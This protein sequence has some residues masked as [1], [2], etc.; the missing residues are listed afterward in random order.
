MPKESV[1][2][3]KQREALELADEIKREEAYQ[4]AL[5]LKLLQ[6]LAKAHAHPDVQ[7]TV[8]DHPEGG[9][10]VEFSFPP[11]PDTSDHFSG[12]DR[13]ELTIYHL[14]MEPYLV[15]AVEGHFHRIEEEALAEA[16]TLKIAQEAYDNLSQVQRDALGLRST[17]RWVR[18]S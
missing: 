14:R 7:A 10:C 1:A 16:R 9:L 8:H 18:T 4:A 13:V 17:S 5:P 2:A 15:E 11:L 3:R 6:L 12:D